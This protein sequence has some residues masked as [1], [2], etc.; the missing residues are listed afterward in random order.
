MC[1]TLLSY[2]KS[3]LWHG[4]DTISLRAPASGEQTTQSTTWYLIA[5][6]RSCT[7]SCIPLFRGLPVGQ[8]AKEIITYGK[9]VA[10]VSQYEQLQIDQSS[11]N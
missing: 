7:G 11:L 4:W 3:N 8:F 2:N 9:D 6:K 5:I 1:Q 10:M